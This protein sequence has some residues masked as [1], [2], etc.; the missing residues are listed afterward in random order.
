MT[1]TTTITITEV[2]GI[3]KITSSAPISIDEGEEK[4]VGCEIEVVDYL[5]W[6]IVPF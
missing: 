5:F 1:S 6:W 4:A 2:I 3:K